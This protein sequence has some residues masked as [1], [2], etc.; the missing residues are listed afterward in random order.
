MPA[1]E[2]PLKVDVCICTFRRTS[3]SATLASID[4]QIGVDDIRILVADND[5]TP[6][7]RALVTAP[8]GRWPRVYIHAPAQNISIARNAL[9]EA[10]S[11]PLIAWIDDDELA[12]PEWLSELVKAIKGHDAAFGVVKA[13]YPEEA[14]DWVKLADL[15]STKPVQTRS[16]IVTGY[17]SNALVKRQTIGSLR[18]DVDLGRSGGEDTEFFARLYASGASFISAPQAVVTEPT[19]TDRL[20][21]DWL[22]K[23]AFRSGQTHAR[24]YLKRNKRLV[25]LIAAS[26]KAAACY[27]MAVLSVFNLP[28]RRKLQ[29]RCALH[30]GVVS[31]LL[32]ASDLQLY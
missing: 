2:A 26:A 9:L 7:A 3:L 4:G 1:H 20:T 30:K 31:R 6:T 19:A 28:V 29:V 17:T 8:G 23:R 16:G 24:S 5:I 18:F 13:L 10:S 27:A 12:D 32:G 14:P 15:H 11:A 21:L 25:G 22:C